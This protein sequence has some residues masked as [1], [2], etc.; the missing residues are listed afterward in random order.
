[1]DRM[2]TVDLEYGQLVTLVGLVRAQLEREDDAQWR[3]H[4]R[5]LLDVLTINGED[6]PLPY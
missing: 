3:E 2:C 5:E 4:L 1:M 6:A